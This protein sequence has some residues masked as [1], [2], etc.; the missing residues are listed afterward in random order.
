MPYPEYMKNE[1]FEPLSMQSMRV[2]SKSLVVSDRV[3]GCALEDGQVVYTDKCSDWML[4]AGDFLGSVDDVYCLNKAIK[5]RL[6]KERHG[7]RP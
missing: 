3:K 5:H 2:D 7:R 6:L 4:G 1:V